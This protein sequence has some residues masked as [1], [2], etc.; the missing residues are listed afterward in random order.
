MSVGSQISAYGYQPSASVQRRLGGVINGY[1]PVGSGGAMG[2]APMYAAGQGTQYQGGVGL[3]FS[4]EDLP[5]AMGARRLG[6]RIIPGPN[7]GQ[8]PYQPS[9][10]VPTSTATT[11]PA[12]ASG[13]QPVGG[14]TPLDPGM[15]VGQ[16]TRGLWQQLGQ[17]IGYQPR[18]F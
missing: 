3:Y 4:P 12:T 13:Y 14:Q 11:L 6:G 9:G 1:Q 2:G 5:S 15:R 8:A 7:R 16:M 10:V 18:G 17:P